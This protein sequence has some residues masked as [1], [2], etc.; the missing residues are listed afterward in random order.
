MDVVVETG[1]TAEPQ[2]TRIPHPT[3]PDTGN[4]WQFVGAVLRGLAI[5]FVMGLI[6]HCRH[7]RQQKPAESPRTQMPNMQSPFVDFQH[8]ELE[9]WTRIGGPR[10]AV[11]TEASR[12]ER[13]REKLRLDA[14]IKEVSETIEELRAKLDAAK[15]G[16]RVDGHGDN[17][18]LP[19][20]LGDTESGAGDK[21]NDELPED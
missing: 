19:V 5:L 2:A 8:K 14:K 15:R 20:T 4:G 3:I 1:H 17:G 18:K 9:K 13:E 7:S 12:Q 21:T 6:S 10:D 11:S 16:K